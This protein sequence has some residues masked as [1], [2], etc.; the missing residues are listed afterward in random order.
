M[1]YPKIKVF[2]IIFSNTCNLQ[3][4]Y[5]FVKQTNICM[6]EEDIDKVLLFIK[7]YPNKDKD[8]TIHLFGGEVLLHQHLI[9]YFLLHN[10]NTNG[11]LIFSN[12]TLFN[13]E[14]LQFVHQFD[15]V[16]FNLSLDGCQQAHDINRV[17]KNQTGSFQ[18]VINGLKLYQEIYETNDIYVKAVLAPNNSEFLID[19]LKIMNQYPYRFD[20][21]ID[22][23]NHWDQQA[24]I[25][26]KT[27]LY[28][29]AD[30]YIENFNYLPWTDLFIIQ[31]KTYTEKRNH[32]CAAVGNFSQLTI[33]PDLKLYTCSRFSNS[34]L[35]IGSISTGVS[36]TNN[37]ILL[38]NTTPENIFEC[39]NCEIF[40]HNNCRYQCPGAIY[41][42]NSSLNTIF[43]NVCELF[44]IYLE[45]CLYVYQHL[46]YN[47]KY[48]EY[49]YAREN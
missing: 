31:L 3:C 10:D 47:T 12:V 45:V 25:N 23:E 9:K 36:N 24:L 5:C 43:P 37:I 27:N 41:E 44:K 42:A 34:D 22:K 40:N 49:L 35:D 8:Y 1:I 6:T 18:Q 16:K 19:T 29:A 4:K 15:N 46:K 14:F 32:I 7:E 13:K 30:Y 39:K 11:V 26:F 33:A 20:Y 38:Q 17:Y 21:T 2:E 28:L 48:R